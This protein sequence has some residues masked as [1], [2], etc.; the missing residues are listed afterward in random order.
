MGVGTDARPKDGDVSM[1]AHCRT[2][3]VYDGT[4]LRWPTDAEW[5]EFMEHPEIQKAIWA[6]GEL[7][8]RR[9]GVAEI[10]EE[11]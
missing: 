7:H 6:I 8:R 10:K 5:E 11:K 9:P 4:G 3:Q 1:C 2:I